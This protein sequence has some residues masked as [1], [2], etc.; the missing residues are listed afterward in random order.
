MNYNIKLDLMK[1]PGATTDGK[2]V[3]L[4]IYGDVIERS[5]D[6]VHLNLVAF[7][8]RRPGAGQSHLI[9]TKLNDDTM[10]TLTEEQYRRIPFIGNMK[11]WE[12]KK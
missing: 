8:L 6:E 4:P 3:T 9:K 2:A 1:L 7:E 5:G 11:P 12:A 10:K